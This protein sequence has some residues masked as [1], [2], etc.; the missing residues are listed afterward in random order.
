MRES[1]LRRFKAMAAKGA[2]ALCAGLPAAAGSVAAHAAEVRRLPKHAVADYQLGGAY[3]PVAG[4]TVVARDSSA[5]PAPGLY[6][7]CYV[8]GFQ[9]QPGTAWPP[10]LLVR[11]RK[12]GPMVDPDW[13]DEHFL[14]I[15]SDSK[16]RAILERQRIAIARCAQAGFDA[17]EFD[18]LDSFTRSKGALKRDD[19]IAFAAL[20]VQVAHDRGLAAGQKNTPGLTNE[21]RRAIGFDFAI[22]EECH[23][24]AECP[25]YGA[26]YGDQVVNVEYVG[27][28]RGR[29]A[30]LCAAPDLPANTV[31]RDRN[32]ISAGKPGY[33]FSHCRL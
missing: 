30:E 2:I 21:E 4:V 17:V 31:I 12:G 3:P 11:A 19:A 29:L 27:N 13:P 8:N 23:R 33:Y 32:L 1:S 10:H 28:M 6:N 9:T 15:S 16:R 20:L 22:S 14:D 25:A 24:Y 5:Q 7:I 26:S 18:N